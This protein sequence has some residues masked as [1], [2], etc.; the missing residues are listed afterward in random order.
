MPDNIARFLDSGPSGTPHESYKSSMLLPVAPEYGTG[1]VLLA[2]A[3][4]RLITNESDAAIDLEDIDGMPDRIATA[5]SQI[6]PRLDRRAFRQAWQDLVFAP[7]GLT[8][9]T[10]RGAQGSRR[11]RQLMPL[12]PQ[13]SRVSGVLGKLRNR[14]QPG[15]LLIS[16]LFSGRGANTGQMLLGLRD[17][18]L[19]TD[20]DD[21]L[22]RF[23]EITLKQTQDLVGRREGSAPPTNEELIKLGERYPPA[24]RHRRGRGFIP[25]ERFVDDL[26]YVIE[27]KPRLTRRQWTVLMESLFR[28]G[29]SMHQLWLCRLNARVWSLCLDAYASAAPELQAVVDRCWPSQ[30]LSDEPLLQLSENAVPRIRQ[31]L[32]EFGYA[33]IGLN[34]LLWTLEDAGLPWNPDV[35]L[36]A[37]ADG[38]TSP[39]DSIHSFLRHVASS[40]EELDAIFAK[41]GWSSLAAAAAVAADGDKRFLSG[42]AIRNLSF[43]VRYSLGQIQPVEDTQRQYDQGYLLYRRDKRGDNLTVRPGPSMLVLTVHCCCRSQGSVPAG[44]DHFRNHLRAYGIGASAD[45]LRAGL[46]SRELERLG[47]VVDSPDAGGGRLLV[48]PF[49][50]GVT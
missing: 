1:E 11:L 3:Y 34:L 23:L 30:D 20:G 12:V 44:M 40:R 29:L 36:G 43:F 6:D 18:L 39:A 14:W 31:I 22:A 24:W 2:S 26:E 32:E 15:N 45:E 48:D 46:T 13:L 7:G 17:S 9:P 19:V 38:L 49:Y 25:S 16:A 4:R 5:A 41:H 42:A 8:S 28:L 35:K 50:L 33:R 10:P 27:L 47:L 37:V 21:Y